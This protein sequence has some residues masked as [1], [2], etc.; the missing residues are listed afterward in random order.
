VGVSTGFNN[1]GTGES[2][3]IGIGIGVGVTVGT[4]VV[5]ASAGVGEA[6]GSVVVDS[7]DLEHE[8]IETR[9]IAASIA[10]IVAFLF[11]SSKD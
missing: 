11:G 7:G 4:G 3:V 5:S 1:I 6:G 8:Q 9:P 10:F 2:V